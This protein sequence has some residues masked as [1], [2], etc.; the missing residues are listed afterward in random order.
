MEIELEVITVNLPEEVITE[1]LLRLPVKPLARFRCVSKPWLFL[2][3]SYKFAKEHL[4]ISRKNNVYIHD[5]LIFGSK[6]LPM[7]LYTCSVQSIIEGPNSSVQIYP[8]ISANF[9]LLFDRVCFDCSFAED[10]VIWLVGSCNGLVCVLFPPNIVVLWN[11]TTRKSKRLPY[12][13]TDLD[14]VESYSFSFAFGY[15]ELHDDY[16]VVEFFGGE[17][18]AGVFE[19][20]VKVYSLRTNSWKTLSNWPGGDTFGGT[21]KF[22]NG[23]VHWLVYECDFD[24]PAE[25]DIV[26][27]DLATDTFIKFPLPNLDDDDDVR[28]E[29]SIL[30]GCLALYCEHNVYM[31][32]WVMKEYGLSESWT[33]AVQIPFLLNLRGHGVIRPRPLFFSVDGKVLINYG[34]SLETYDLSNPQSHQFSSTFSVEAT[35]YFESLVSPNLDDE[36]I[37][38]RTLPPEIITEI[39]LRLPVKSLLRFKSVS[40]EWLSLISS[41][42]FVKA[43]L[44]TS[45]KNNSYIHDKLIF[46]SK[47]LPMDLYSCSIQ[48]II[49]GSDLDVYPTIDDNILFD[50]VGFDCPFVGAFDVIW[51]VGSCNGLVCVNL[52]PNILILWNPATWKSKMLPDSGTDLDFEYYSITYAF[53]YDELHDDYKVVEFFAA[54]FEAGV[55]ENR[56]KVYSLRTNFWKTLSNWPGGDTFGGTGKFLNGAVHWSVCDFDRPD[57]WVIVSHDLAT[58]NFTELPLPNLDDDDVRVVVNILEGRLALYCEHSTHMDVWVMKEYGVSESWTKFVRIPFFLDLRD[59]EFVRPCPLFFSE[60]GKVLINYGTSLFLYNPESHHQFGS[61]VSVHATTYFESLVSPS[62]DDEV[63]IGQTMPAEIITEILLRLPVKSLVRFKS[64]SKE[65]LSLISS[66]RFVKAHLKTSTTKNDVKLIFGPTTNNNQDLF[67]GSINSMIEVSVF[68]GG[69]VYSVDDEIFPFLDSVWFDSLIAE[70]DAEKRIVGSCNGLVCLSLSR[71]TVILVNPATRISRILP[72]SSPNNF[73][74]AFKYY[75]ISYSLGYDEIHSDYKVVEIMHFSHSY[76]FWTRVKVYSMR[77]NSWKDLMNWPGGDT[78]SR[79]GKFLNGS[80]HWSVG[81]FGKC[82]IVSLDLATETFILL[83]LPNNPLDIDD[84]LVVEVDILGGCVAVYCNYDAYMDVW[85]MK[86]SWTRV[87]QIPFFMD[88]SAHEF[89]VPHPL[90]LSVDGKILMNYGSSLKIYDSSNPQPHNFDTDS[91]RSHAIWN[92]ADESKNVILRQMMDESTLNLDFSSC[93]KRREA[94]QGDNAKPQA[95]KE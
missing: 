12:S 85:V 15:D 23:S 51:L 58:D 14:Y 33:K 61:T 91:A 32:V 36:V 34:M 31:D 20:Q 82:G 63:I 88:L 53:G 57:K 59:H 70:P 50:Q 24:R 18:V 90:F 6:Y 27:H 10:D 94:W 52:S 71:H 67:T 43:H 7:D 56:V 16:K 64:V 9:P 25:W 4:K 84:A 49:E 29:I 30:E 35:T 8:A 5:K 26:S 76:V 28:V 1:I 55:Y 46:G 45:T 75:D 86:E 22:L 37:L 66:S 83:P 47:T 21:G 60:D 13:G 68:I 38:G 65:W 89:V 3:S 54:E 2:I 39:L 17:L 80:L 77:T 19:T 95:L 40:K 69:C 78:C 92:V 74:L 48:S 93:S 11:P 72:N 44:K 41:S 79:S 73:Y 62:L 42:R 81:G 87:V